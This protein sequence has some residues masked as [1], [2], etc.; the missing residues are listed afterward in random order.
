M[1]ANRQAF[2]L[3]EFQLLAISRLWHCHIAETLSPHRPRQRKAAVT[4][5]A[6]QADS[7]SGIDDLRSIP[8][9]PCAVRLFP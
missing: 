9:G 5:A 3:S 6:L 7:V 4:G 1:A 8:G 2:L